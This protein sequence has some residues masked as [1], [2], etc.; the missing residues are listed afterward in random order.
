MI[1]IQYLNRILNDA[2]RR[3]ELALRRKA[4]QNKKAK[5]RGYNNNNNFEAKPSTGTS[6]EANFAYNAGLARNKRVVIDNLDTISSQSSVK[7][8]RLEEYKELDKSYNYEYFQISRKD[9]FCAILRIGVLKTD[10]NESLREKTKRIKAKRKASGSKKKDK[11]IAH[12]VVLT[13]GAVW[14]PEFVQIDGAFRVGALNFNEENWIKLLTPGLNQSINYNLG[15]SGSITSVRF[16]D[17]SIVMGNGISSDSITGLSEF[18]LNW[19]DQNPSTGGTVNPVFDINSK[20]STQLV[21]DFYQGICN[22]ANIRATTGSNT[23]ADTRFAIINKSGATHELIYTARNPGLTTPL[24][25]TIGLLQKDVYERYKIGLIDSIDS[26][27]SWGSPV[28]LDRARTKATATTYYEV[29]DDGSHE[30]FSVGLDLEYTGGIL[31]KGYEESSPGGSVVIANTNQE[32]TNLAIIL[33]GITKTEYSVKQ[34][35]TDPN[36]SDAAHSYASKC[37]VLPESSADVYNNKLWMNY[38][39]A[40]L[41]SS[42]STLENDII[43]WE[44]W[45]Q[46]HAA[47]VISNPYWE[48]S[49]V[50]RYGRLNYIIEDNTGA[51]RQEQ[52][53]KWCV[54]ETLPNGSRTY[55]WMQ[56]PFDTFKSNPF[57]SGSVIK[58]CSTDNPGPLAVSDGTGGIGHTFYSKLTGGLLPLLRYAESA[59]VLPDEKKLTIKLSREGNLYICQPA[60]ERVLN[61][62][63]FDPLN[64]N[65]TPLKLIP[66]SIGNFADRLELPDESFLTIEPSILSMPF[67]IQTIPTNARPV[68]TMYFRPTNYNLTA[69]LGIVSLGHAKLESATTDSQVTIN[70]YTSSGN[71]PAIQ[72]KNF[73]YKVIG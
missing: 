12:I 3:A 23:I 69:S 32:K 18:S 19:I 29:F 49:G 68:A 25:A 47:Y 28:A 66:F 71:S 41:P 67:E 14:E 1:P 54:S 43:L 35:N 59:H 15:F 26:Q 13:Y 52:I 42:G 33:N 65:G 17:K 48:P 44:D 50:L 45:R 61:D 51:K 58:T 10:R 22:F 40:G 2:Y 8:E 9:G 57:N 56:G 5:T 34:D 38:Y 72:Y 39:T 24:P 73:Y 55:K 7:K 37:F 27:V 36:F 46:P 16:W 6:R 53:C 4:E 64:D 21:T 60:P 62:P 63:T 30:L 20:P 31:P 70:D 11:I